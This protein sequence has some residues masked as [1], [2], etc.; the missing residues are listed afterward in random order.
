MADWVRI[1][2]VTPRAQATPATC[3]LNCYAMLYQFRGLDI[4]TIGPKLKAAGLNVDNMYNNGIDNSEMMKAASSLGLKPWGA[5]QSWS[6]SDFKGWLAISP[7]WCA[8]CW[9]NSPHVV[10]VIGASD[11]EIEFIN[12][13]PEVGTG[14]AEIERRF[15][16]DFIHGDR[17]RRPGTDY[18]LNREKNPDGS[19]NPHGRITGGQIGAI[20]VWA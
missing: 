12:P 11:D 1:K 13:W 14:D 17:N 2:G 9:K 6:P 18:Y 3:W 4:A 8:G 15:A 5:G 7:V 16:N 10:V 19:R 20:A